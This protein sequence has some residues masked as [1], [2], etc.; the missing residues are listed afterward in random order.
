MKRVL[1]PL[2][3]AFH[4]S[5]EAL[6]PVRFFVFLCA[7]GYCLFMSEAPLAAALA[8]TRRIAHPAVWLAGLV[9]LAVALQAPAYNVSV[10]GASCA[11]GMAS[12]PRMVA[13]CW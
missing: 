11:C 12:E 5:I 3:L 10:I 9:A 1:I 7:A 4:L 2:G 6:M 13:Y 8:R